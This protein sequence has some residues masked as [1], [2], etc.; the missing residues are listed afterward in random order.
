[1]SKILEAQPSESKKNNFTSL[2]RFAT[3]SEIVLMVIGTICSML[4]GTSIAVVALLTGN[5][6]DSYSQQGKA[7]EE[8]K[9]NMLLFVYFGIGAFVVGAIMIVTWSIA[10]EQ[11]VISCRKQYFRAKLD[12]EM[13]WFDR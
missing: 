8:A 13:A 1:M 11:Q 10:T 6:V 3:S 7:V 4:M 12:Q 2:F 9:R 5:L